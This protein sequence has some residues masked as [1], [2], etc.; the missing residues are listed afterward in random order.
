MYLVAKVMALTPSSPDEPEKQ[1]RN[2]L[3]EV[4][5]GKDPQTKPYGRPFVTYPP[6]VESNFRQFVVVWAESSQYTSLDLLGSRF[7]D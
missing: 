6:Y 7:T 1:K 3:L 4:V 2:G 5:V